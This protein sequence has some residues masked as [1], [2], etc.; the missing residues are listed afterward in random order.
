L[1]AVLEPLGVSNPPVFEIAGVR[2]SEGEGVVLLDSTGVIED[3]GEIEDKE[4]P[5]GSWEV[6]PIA[7]IV[8]SWVIAGDNEVVPVKVLT[9]VTVDSN[10]VVAV[11]TR[12]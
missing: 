11:D 7:E 6:L 4:E 8:A 10:T 12:L 1:V 3:K 2:E 9:P 5:D